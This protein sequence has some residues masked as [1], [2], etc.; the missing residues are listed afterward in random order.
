MTK[1]TQFILI[2]MLVILSIWIMLSLFV[3]MEGPYRKKEIGNKDAKIKVLIVYD[4]D[5]FYN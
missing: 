4:P 1:P 3:Q 2:A 5:P